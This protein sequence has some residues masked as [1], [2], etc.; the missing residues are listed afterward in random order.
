[1][2]PAMAAM[3]PMAAKMGPAMMAGKKGGGGGGKKGGGGGAPPAPPPAVTSGG[4]PM[5]AAP[6]MAMSMDPFTSTRRAYGPGIMSD[7]L[8]ENMR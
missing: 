7:F 1:M 6:S 3:A 4:A 8:K 2:I 5:P